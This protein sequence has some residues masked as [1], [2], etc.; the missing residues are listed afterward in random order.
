MYMSPEQAEGDP[1]LDGRSD[2]YS[3]GCVLFEAL[4]GVPPFQGRSAQAILVRRLTESPPAL[5]TLSPGIPAVVE[6]AVARALAAHAGRSVRHGRRAVLGA[7]R[8]GR[9]AAP[10]WAAALI[11]AASRWPTRPS[12][13]C[14]SSI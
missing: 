7:G 12:R 5:R 13:C 2:I 10:G 4:T 14:P 1:D 3:L 8:G 6:A 9:R 11:P